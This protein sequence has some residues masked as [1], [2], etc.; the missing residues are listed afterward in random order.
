MPA[1]LQ[2]LRTLL[3]GA[4]VH[5]EGN[6]TACIARA[7]F[8]T[9]LSEELS[10]EC[11]PFQLKDRS[12]LG[13]GGVGGRGDCGGGVDGRDDVGGGDGNDGGRDGR[14]GRRCGG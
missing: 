2:G 7:T 4:N 8:N 5:S 3:R 14:G 1:L 6:H 10:V 12:F 13:S 11:G 9:D